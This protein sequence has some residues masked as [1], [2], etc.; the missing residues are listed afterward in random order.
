LGD[1]GDGGELFETYALVV[2]A[3][4]PFRKKTHG[5]QDAHQQREKSEREFP[6]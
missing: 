6:E 5:E 1:A 2:G 3:E 4:G